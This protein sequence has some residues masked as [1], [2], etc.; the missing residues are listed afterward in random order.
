MI[1]GSIQEEDI[2]IVNIYATN[3]EAPQYI[4]QMLIAIKGEINSNT[5]IVGD[6]NTPLTSD[7]HRS[8]RQKINKDTRALNDTLDL[9][10]LINIDRTFYPKAAEYTVFSH[11]HGTFPRIDH[12]LGH[13][14]SLNKLKKTD[15]ILSIFSENNAMRLEINCKKDNAKEYK[16]ME[17]KQYVTK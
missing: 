14:A 4:R 3:T 1:K 11:A 16:H 6:C 7:V 8:S 9:M 10:D 12:M 17:A 2:T 5:I 13:K 15:I